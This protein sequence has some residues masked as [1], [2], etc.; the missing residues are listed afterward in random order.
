VQSSARMVVLHG[1]ARFGVVDE[2][3]GEYLVTRFHHVF[4]LPLVPVGS[5]WVT[6]RDGHA[7]YGRTCRLSW[8]SVFAGYV[9]MWGLVITIVALAMAAAGNFVVILPATFIGPLALA[10]LQLRRLRDPAELRRVAVQ[11]PALGIALDPALLPR[12]SADI[13][14]GVAHERFDVV[15]GGRTPVDVAVH[16]AASEVQAAYAFVILRLRAVTRRGIEAVNARLASED[17]LRFRDTLA[18]T[19]G[20]YRTMQTPTLAEPPLL[21]GYALRAR[22]WHGVIATLA[23]WAA[24]VAAF[25]P[26]CKVNC[27]YDAATIDLARAGVKKLVYES[28]PQW[29]SKPTTSRCPALQDLVYYGGSAKDPWGEEYIVLCNHAWADADGIA[30]FS[31]GEDGRVGTDDDINSWSVE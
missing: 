8:R 31:K 16:G 24:C 2:I 14:L 12:D 19:D 11:R 7:L 21:S 20:P 27:E 29:R 15:S 18:P 3:D 23:S 30:V 10:S 28:Y 9:R 4:L 5:E 22:S 17:L 13:L 26:G 25:P 1:T 6:R